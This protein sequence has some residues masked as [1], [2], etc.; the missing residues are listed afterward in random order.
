MAI[1]REILIY[2][3]TL[4]DNPLRVDPFEAY[5]E[6]FPALDV[7]SVRF[8]G[9]RDHRFDPESVHQGIPH[10]A[11]RPRLRAVMA[12]VTLLA[13]APFAWVANS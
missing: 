8:R 1:R 6:L 9:K 3:H 4:A 7:S 12:A 10:F 2:M 5:E 13:L 11:H